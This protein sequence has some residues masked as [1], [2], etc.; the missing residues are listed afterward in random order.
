MRVHQLMISAAVALGVTAHAEEPFTYQCTGNSR[1]LPSGLALATVDWTFRIRP[2]DQ[3]A[4]AE[5]KTVPIEMNEYR[6][7]F[8]LQGNHWISI[9]RSNGHFHVVKPIENPERKM[10]EYLL[11][12]GECKRV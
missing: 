2:E 12:E 3:L 6:I 1:I 5:G 4:E 11:Y 8:P 10:R 7:S 9:T